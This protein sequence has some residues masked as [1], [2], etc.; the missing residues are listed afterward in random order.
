M[1]QTSREKELIVMR[2]F[3]EGKKVDVSYE[4]TS[5]TIQ[6]RSDLEKYNDLLANTYVDI[7]EFSDKGIALPSKANK[8]Q[9]YTISLNQSDKVV[10]RIFNNNSWK[11][12]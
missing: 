3:I 12:C 11:I 5:L 1:I 7:P 8:N 6:W 10:Q 2:D 4:D 9:T